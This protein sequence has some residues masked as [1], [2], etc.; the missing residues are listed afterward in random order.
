VAREA[1]GQWDPT[2]IV[3]RRWLLSDAPAWFRD[4]YGRRG[5]AFADWLRAHPRIKPLVRWAFDRC[6]ERGRA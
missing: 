1:Y 4:L 6:I 3:F 2:W 5:P